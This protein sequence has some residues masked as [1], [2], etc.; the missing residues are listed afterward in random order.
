VNEPDI[1]LNAGVNYRYGKWQTSASIHYQGKV[2]RRLSEVGSQE[3]PLGVGVTLNLNDYRSQSVSSW[4]ELNLK[5]E[6]ELV[7]GTALGL[8]VT[9]ALGSNGKLAKSGPF[10]FDYQ[11]PGSLAQIFVRSEF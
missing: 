8:K 3:L 4:T 2:N 1:K 7:K 5:L 11:R 9:N 10:P 6:R